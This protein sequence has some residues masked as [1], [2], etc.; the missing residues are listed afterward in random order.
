MMEMKEL[1]MDIRK[2]LRCAD[3]Y[4]KEAMKHKEEFPELSGVYHRIANDKMVH[5][6][7]LS[8]QARHMAEKHHIDALW[9]VEDYMIK[10]DMSEVRRCL[11]SYK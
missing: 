10:H 5:A 11:E 6:D 8:V 9:D 1:L 7:L 4:A 3:K 2:E